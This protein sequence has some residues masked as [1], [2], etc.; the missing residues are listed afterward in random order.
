MSSIF[1]QIA[2]RRTCLVLTFFSSSTSCFLGRKVFFEHEHLGI[3]LRLEL[4]LLGLAQVREAGS[5]HVR[6][7]GNRGEQPAA[8]ALYV[9]LY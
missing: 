7:G 4:I 8:T 5:E 1:R 2:R 9:L 3:S 6:S